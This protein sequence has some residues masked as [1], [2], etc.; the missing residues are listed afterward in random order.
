MKALLL[1]LVSGVALLHGCDSRPTAATD[2][3]SA[4]DTTPPVISTVILNR[5]PNPTVPLAAILSLSTDEPSEMTVRID[6]GEQTWDATSSDGFATE[7]SLMVL[8]MRLGRLHHITAVVNDR[9]GNVSETPPLPMEMPPLPADLTQPELITRNPDLM[10]PGVRM[11]KGFQLPA[12]LGG[13]AAPTA[14]LYIVDDRGEIIWYYR[15]ELEVGDARRMSNGNLLFST[16]DS[17]RGVE[18][19]MLGNVVQQWHAVGT[20]TDVPE[21]STPVEMGSL[22]HEVAEMPSGNLLTLSSE[23]R[24]VQ[25]FPTSDSDPDA[26]PGPGSVIGDVIVEFSRDGTIVREWKLLDIMDPYRIG[27][28]SLDGSFW[29]VR[30]GPLIEDLEAEPIRDWAHAN[31]LMYDPSDD[32][33][34]VSLYHQDA[35]VKIDRDTG[36]LL[37]ILGAPDNW[38]EPWSSRRLQPVGDLEWQYREH[39][40]TITPQGTMVLFDNGGARAGAFQEQLPMELRYSRIVEYDIDA[41]SMEVEQVWSY[42][43]PGDEQ[44]FSAFLGDADWLPETGNILITDGARMV[45]REG[46]PEGAGEVEEADEAED[47]DD[48]DEADEPSDII[49]FLQNNVFWGRVFEI[50][51][52]QPAEIVFEVQVKDAEGDGVLVYRAEHLPSLYP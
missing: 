42:G 40:P 37:W 13:P 15:S 17:S 9:S 46:E 2:Q 23:L 3:L 45:V 28:E 36:E 6:D 49:D 8:G 26:L 34:I 12:G 1:P 43:G 32:S 24:V 7:H 4:G 25:D 14:V 11:F 27:I 47:A 31:A 41:E 33:Y 30:Y 38:Q 16:G 39:A 50:T 29:A 18:I 21:G 20:A 44:F 22:H 5:N 48:T 51:H 52:T 35:V 10:E 19:D